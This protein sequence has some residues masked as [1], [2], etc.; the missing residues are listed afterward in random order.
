[1]LNCCFVFQHFGDI[2][3]VFKDSGGSTADNLKGTTNRQQVIFRFWRTRIRYDGKALH[4]EIEHVNRTKSHP[5]P[6]FFSGTA[7]EGQHDWDLI[8]NWLRF[9]IDCK[10]VFLELVLLSWK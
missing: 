7:W 9:E 4:W 6:P 1:M 2:D 3:Q 5:E 10:L 8:P